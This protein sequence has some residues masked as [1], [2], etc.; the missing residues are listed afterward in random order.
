MTKDIKISNKARKQLKHIHPDDA[1]KILIALK[2]LAETEVGLDIKAKEWHGLDE[3]CK[4]FG[5]RD[6]DVEFTVP[7][8]ADILRKKSMEI[9]RLVKAKTLK[10]RKV[11]GRYMINK[12]DLDKYRNGRK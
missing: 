5:V 4:E 12:E 11:G 9:H 3:I 1:R 8:V 10:A 7:Q 2:K 6:T